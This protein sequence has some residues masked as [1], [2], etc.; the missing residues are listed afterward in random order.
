MI[1]ILYN[2]LLS[3][4][5]SK[6]T[7]MEFEELIPR[8]TNTDLLRAKILNVR[9]IASE[10]GRFLHCIDRK[11]MTYSDS[12]EPD[13]Y[14]VQ[15]FDTLGG[16]MEH[17]IGCSRDG[18]HDPMTGEIIPAEPH[19]ITVDGEA[20]IMPG[21]EAGIPLIAAVDVSDY[22]LHSNDMMDP[23]ISLIINPVRMSDISILLDDRT[24]RLMRF[25]SIR[26][27]TTYQLILE[28]QHLNTLENLDAL[29]VNAGY[30]AE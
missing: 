6:G 26:N 10:K 9:Y 18:R 22:P 4:N 2:F 29:T 13:R 1:L 14:A 24:D 12:D 20:V 28:Q 8:D 17:L 23:G 7:E 30:G 5:L 11:E 25:R 27:A 3:N 21:Y 16:A 15:A 19:H